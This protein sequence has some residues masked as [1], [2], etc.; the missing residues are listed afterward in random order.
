MRI[1]YCYWTFS[2]VFRRRAVPGLL[3][4]YPLNYRMM[5]YK[6]MVM[7]GRG[8]NVQNYFI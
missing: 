5:R 3:L 2:F 8:D 6:P 7:T 1:E 4:Q